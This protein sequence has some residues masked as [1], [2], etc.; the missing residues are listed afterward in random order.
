ME[1]RRGRFPRGAAVLSPIFPKS[2]PFPPSSSGGSTEA[3]CGHFTAPIFTSSERQYGQV[4][5][6]GSRRL[7]LFE[8]MPRAALN[9][10]MT[11]KNHRGGDE[12]T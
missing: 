6:V 3:Q 10:F 1:K 12:K 4:L 5:V 11:A 9:A 7:L 2:E 8:T